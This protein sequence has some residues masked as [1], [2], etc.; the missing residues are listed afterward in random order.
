VKGDSR[1]SSLGG[2]PQDQARFL[3]QADADSLIAQAAASAVLPSDPGNPTARRLC[4]RR[5]EHARVNVW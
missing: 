2:A 3:L 1:G 4:S 5:D